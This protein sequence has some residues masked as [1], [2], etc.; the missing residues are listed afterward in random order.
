ML[1]ASRI[2][3]EGRGEDGVRQVRFVEAEPDEEGLAVVLVLGGEGLQVLRCH[4]LVALIRE[5]RPGLEIEP[6]IQQVASQGLFIVYPCN[7]A[8][9]VKRR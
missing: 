9:N 1:G 7:R 4:H 6:G 8:R 2:G 3:I 5:V